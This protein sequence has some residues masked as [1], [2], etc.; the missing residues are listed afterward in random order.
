MENFDTVVGL[1]I[2]V[3]L[4]TNSKA[5]CRD[6][7]KFGTEPNT[8]IGPISL[9]LPG[10]L[11]ML[12]RVQVL[13]AAKLG[14]A[15]DSEIV[16]DS[17]FDRKNYFYPDL[18]KGYQITQDNHPICVGGQFS[19]KTKGGI[20]TI[21][22]HHLHM[23]E[24]AGKSIHDREPDVS[25]VDLNRAGTPLLEVVTEPDF[26]NGEEVSDFI[27]AFQILLRYLDIS[28]A[29]ME[30]GS[31]RC[32][33]NVSVKESGATKLGTRCEI[34]N[35][36]SK[37]FAKQA[38]SYEAKRQI[39]LINEGESIV[40]ETRLFDAQEGVTYSMRKKEDAL[41]YRYFPEPD[42]QCIIL[43]DEMLENIKSSIDYLPWQAEAELTN[44]HGV[45]EY[46][47][48]IIASKKYYVYS[49]LK[50]IENVE[51]KKLCSNFMTNQLIP[52]AEN[53]EAEKL[54]KMYPSLTELLN[55]ISRGQLSTSLAYKNILPEIVKN[56]E[57]S[58]QAYAEEK[59][60]LISENQDDSV[61]LCQKIL[62]S[63]PDK[64]SAYKSGKKGLIGFFMGEAMKSGVKGLNPKT[65]Q[66]EF[67]KLLK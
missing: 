5:F 67:E 49:Y 8:N 40:Q 43:K 6:L 55:L 36:N 9:A 65:L 61:E 32:D 52:I 1:E 31:L 15:L 58:V 45:S 54:A 20:K 21:R 64:V 13:S 53:V 41:D 46:N 14:I 23:E 4:N 27:A 51:D 60:L 57:L 66:N 39:K 63:N 18:P 3:Q 25:C 42:L 48:S 33:C 47:A 44:D 35:V 50:L 16:K 34:K 10:T 29:N 26:S 19:F 7:N 59:K 12:N 17:Y 62:D 11:P 2:H 56:P 28:D 37:K 38:I 30:E 22:I 24:D